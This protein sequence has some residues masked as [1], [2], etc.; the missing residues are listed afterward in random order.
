MYFGILKFTKDETPK[1]GEF[2]KVK[3]T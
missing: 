3:N 1:L 2:K